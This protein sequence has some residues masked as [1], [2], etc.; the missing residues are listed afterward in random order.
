M[1]IFSLSLSLFF[2][3]NSIGSIP[4]FVAVLGRYTGKRQRVIILRELL[5]AL[6]ILLLFTFFGERFLTAL[7][8]SQ[9]VV[10]IG[11]G[12][13]LFLISIGMIFP[14]KSDG[15]EN[16]RE[17]PLIVP[18]AMPLIAGPG[19][20]TTVMVYSDQI[21]NPFFLVGA[22]L[23][24]WLPSL[25]ILL[26]ASFV[27]KLLGNKGLHALQRLG[28]MLICLL[29]VQMIASSTIDLIKKSF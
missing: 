26:S 11:G 1:S 8:I 25:A 22:I 14:K 21:E 27:N 20:I 17:E 6:G 4:V 24:A 28:G 13:V 9:P 2:I 23:L 16:N 18:L 29:A 7:G 10:G 12:T 5:I 15:T 3:M 19:A